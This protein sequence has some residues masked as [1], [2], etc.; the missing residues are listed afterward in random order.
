MMF[1]EKSAKKQRGVEFWEHQR[2]VLGF[3]CVTSLNE[4]KRFFLF[5]F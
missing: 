3:L 1:L 5:F 4:Q 2:W